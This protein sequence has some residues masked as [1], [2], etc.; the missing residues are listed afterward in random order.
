M[1]RKTGVDSHHPLDLKDLGVLHKE[2]I[3]ITKV[4]IENDNYL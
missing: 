3:I 1:K 2:K 4:G